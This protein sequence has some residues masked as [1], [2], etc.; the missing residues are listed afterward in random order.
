MD[1]SS[2]I[3]S[4]WHIIVSYMEQKDYVTCM[5]IDPAVKF[6]RLDI[7]QRKLKISIPKILGQSNFS[8]I[9]ELQC[10]NNKAITD[11]SHFTQL[12]WLDCS[13]CSNLSLKGIEALKLEY[14]NCSGNLWVTELNSF[15]YLKA[16]ECEDCENLTM[17]GIEGLKQLRSFNCNFNDWVKSLENFKNLTCL[18]CRECPNLDMKSI[19]SLK[20]QKLDARGNV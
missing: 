2:I 15:K 18:N 6:Q 11:L 17:Q 4:V 13:G 19:K 7:R 5:L 20:L 12:R 10:A 9:E 8:Y 1:S 3:L 16:L 14:L